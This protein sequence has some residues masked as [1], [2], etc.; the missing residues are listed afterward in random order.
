MNGARPTSSTSDVVVARCPMRIS[1][2]L[3]VARLFC[4]SS[5][6]WQLLLKLWCPS[7][8][9]ESMDHGLDQ[10][11]VMILYPALPAFYGLVA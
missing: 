10:P 4:E 1:R 5:K 6:A 8:E 3:L 7:A 11:E 2:D 9:L